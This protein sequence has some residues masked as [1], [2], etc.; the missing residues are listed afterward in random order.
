MK[1][2][3]II[4]QFFY[5]SSPFG[6]S[7][8]KNNYT[9]FW[10]IVPSLRIL[11]MKNIFL[12]IILFFLSQFHALSQHKYFQTPEDI[13]SLKQELMIFKHDTDRIYLLNKLSWAYRGKSSD[14]AMFYAQKALT[15]SRQI[16]FSKGESEAL[17]ILGFVQFAENPA[18]ALALSL[19]ALQVAEKNRDDWQRAWAME[20]IGIG[21]RDL[22]NYPKALS[23]L[24]QAKNI[25][26]SIRD[27]KMETTI[28][29][30]LGNI[31][32]AMNLLDSGFHYAQ[33]VFEKSERLN[34]E[35]MLV[36]RFEFMGA[37]WEK[38]GNRKLA[39]WYYQEALNLKRSSSLSLNARL[40]YQV[41]RLYRQLNIPDSSIYFAKQSL[42]HAQQGLYYNNIIDAATLLAETYEKIDPNQSLNYYKIT[43]AAKDSLS[44]IN[45]I[46]A[47]QNLLNFDEQERKYE[48]EAAQ[49]VYK[50]KVRQYG[51]F[52]GLGISSTR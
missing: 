13:D 52:A 38:K 22:K 16:K 5:C 24:Y 33:L 21:Y 20:R 48:V 28:Q 51:L 31:Y 19:R 45:K 30:Q 11:S 32:L 43:L 8:P 34:I 12:L 50:N 7:F 39:L 1:L 44:N 4:F 46:S 36:N 18:A 37:A 47:M 27:F 23:Y 10:F 3:T 9:V 14:S 41:A 25:F 17:V 15:Y 6:L 35:W 40:N 26:C 49:I 29:F 42:I 2:K